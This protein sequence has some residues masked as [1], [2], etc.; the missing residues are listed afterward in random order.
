M[1]TGKS[2][3]AIAIV[4]TLGVQFALAL[5]LGYLGGNYLDDRFGTGQLFLVIGM[6]AGVGA[7]IMG[8]AK[9]IQPFILEDYSEEGDSNSEDG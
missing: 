4:S 7:G 1:K 5:F 8:A 6:F 9:L 2:L 3:Q